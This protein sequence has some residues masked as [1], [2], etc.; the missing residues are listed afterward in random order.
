MSKKEME[1]N[2]INYFSGEISEEEKKN[3]LGWKDE[4]YNNY[5][6]FHKYYNLFL[7][8][9]IFNNAISKFGGYLF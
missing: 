2:L 8:L 9:K 5:S 1:I 6:L 3:L 4:S 7:S